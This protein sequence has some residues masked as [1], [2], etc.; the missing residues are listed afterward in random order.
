MVPRRI[1][2]PVAAALLLLSLP[3]CS[4]Q[5]REPTIERLD[6]DRSYDAACD[7]TWGTT[8]EVLEELGAEISEIERRDQAGLITTDF[9]VLSDI[10]ADINHLDRVAYSRGGSFIGGRYALTVTVRCLQ[11]GRSKVKVVTRIEGYMGEEL[12]YQVLRSTGLL[13]REIFRRIGARLGAE[14]AATD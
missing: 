4:V 11:D 12:G 7:P 5:F 6:P 14:P 8:Q 10:G 13:E 9:T 2:S 1:R 3:A